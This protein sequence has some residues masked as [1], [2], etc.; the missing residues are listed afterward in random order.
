MIKAFKLV[1]VFMSPTF[2]IKINPILSQ[3]PLPN[4]QPPILLVD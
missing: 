2:I 4:D 3:P 1:L